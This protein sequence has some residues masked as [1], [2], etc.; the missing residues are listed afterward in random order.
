[1]RQEDVLKVIR[2]RGPLTV[3]EILDT[4]GVDL[5]NRQ[6][7]RAMYSEAHQCIRALEK[8]DLV[9]KVASGMEGYH[10]PRW[11]WDVVE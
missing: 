11:K 9:Q 2:E 10:V 8:Y 7:K 3:V 4:L 5:S 1:M 6:I